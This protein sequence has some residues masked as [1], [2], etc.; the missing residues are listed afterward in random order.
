VIFPQD[1]FVFASAAL[2]M[3]GGTLLPSN[4]LL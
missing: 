1:V 2:G 4:M 3:A